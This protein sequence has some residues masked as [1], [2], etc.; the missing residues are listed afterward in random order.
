MIGKPPSLSEV[1]KLTY[2][3]LEDGRVRSIFGVAESGL[4]KENYLE[5]I[6]A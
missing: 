5:F 4:E 6:L 3:R 2:Y 1:V